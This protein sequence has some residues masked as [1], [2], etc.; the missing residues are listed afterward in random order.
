MKKI[1]LGLVA[2]VVLLVLVSGCG[3]NGLVRMDEDVKTKWSNVETQYQRRSDLIPNLVS[4]V[5]GAAKFEQGTLT[6]V[7][8]ARASASK[9]TIDPDKLNA[10]NI[11]KYQQAQGQITQALGKLM[12]LTENYPELKATQQF[13]DLSA[14]LEGTENRITVSRKDFNESVQVFNTKV[15]SFPTNLTAGIF[16]FSSK[17]AFKADAGS[18]NAPKVEF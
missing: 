16:G 9:I 14:Q 5:K 15:R 17:T 7:I 8:E 11:A 12:V 4:T 13:S 10:D 1:V 6:A 18:Q 3:Y 2:V